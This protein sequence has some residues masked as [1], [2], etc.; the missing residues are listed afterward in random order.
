MGINCRERGDSRAKTEEKFHSTV[1]ARVIG[2]EECGLW[3]IRYETVQLSNPRRPRRLDH[4]PS[5]LCVM[6]SD[7]KVVSWSVKQGSDI[8][9]CHMSIVT[10]TLTYI[11]YD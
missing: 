10:D 5:C 7:Q 11:N 1:G 9:S 4:S 8:V 6:L 3:R 2:L